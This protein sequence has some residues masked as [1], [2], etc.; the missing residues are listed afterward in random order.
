MTELFGQRHLLHDHCYPVYTQ[1][2][3][4]DSP[5]LF[6]QLTKIS[7]FTILAEAGLRVRELTRQQ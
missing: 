4:P 7:L 3:R 1:L 6:N 5:Y 2:R